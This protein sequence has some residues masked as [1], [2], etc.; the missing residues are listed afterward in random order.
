MACAFYISLLFSNVCLVLSQCKT[1]L[2]LFYLLNTFSR[3]SSWFFHTIIHYNNNSN[4]LLFSVAL[5]LFYII[6]FHR[7]PLDGLGRVP[8]EHGELDV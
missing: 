4:C 1:L 8:V 2:R 6:F 5:I 3:T 7:L